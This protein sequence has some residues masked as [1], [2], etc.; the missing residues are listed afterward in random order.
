MTKIKTYVEKSTGKTTY[1][2]SHY[3]GIKDPL[4]GKLEYVTRRGFN[5]KE[6]AEFEL[7]KIK[8]ELKNNSFQ[9]PSNEIVTFEEVYREWNLGYVNTVRETTYT[10]TSQQ[11]RK[12]ILPAFGKRNIRDITI[13]ECQ[14]KVNEWSKIYK[15]FK[16]LKS[17]VQRV[18][19]H[20]LISKYIQEN[21]MK[22]VKM[23]K[24]MEDFT[25]YKK[26]NYYT[27]EEVKAFFNTLTEHFS[28][29]EV[30]MFHLLAYTGMRKGELGALCWSDINFED[31]TIKI[32]K[33]LAYVNKGYKVYPPKTKKSNR[34]IKIHDITI[35]LLKKWK[36]QQAEELLSFGINPNQKEQWVF[37][38]FYGDKINTPI[39]PDTTN[40]ILKK[41]MKINKDLPKITPHGFRHTHASIL[42]EASTEIKEI[43]ERLCHAGI[44]IT[45]NT[46]GHL[47]EKAKENTA[48]K[49]AEALNL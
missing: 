11:F 32:Y 17:A 21:P 26:E 7:A 48:N 5:S 38:M 28:I 36:K 6:E 30:A 15:N 43:S 34:T 12:Y 33:N 39:H 25:H 20:A 31:K 1:W 14:I 22:Y 42:I 37:S 18:L 9:K 47:T 46:Y 24:K 49:F 10:M 44:E 45:G 4:T 35:E 23:P 16:V 27:V 2:F 41:V 29:K 40:N 13:K 8:L 3:T 19:D